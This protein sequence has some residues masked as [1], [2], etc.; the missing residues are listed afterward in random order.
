MVYARSSSLRSAGWIAV[1]AIVCGSALACERSAPG[2]APGIAVTVLDLGQAVAPAGER[3]A[4][5]VEPITTVAVRSQVDGAVEALAKV[6][7]Q[8]GAAHPLQIGDTV[9]AGDF[10]VQIERDTYQQRVGVE[11]AK[12]DSAKVSLALQL[13]EYDRAK[14]LFKGGVESKEF[15]DNARTAY[16]SAQAAVAQQQHSLNEAKIHLERTRVTSPLDGV[17][18]KVAIEPG[19]TVRPQSLLAQV[20]DVSSVNVTFGVPAGSVAALSIGSMLHMTFDAIAGD[21]YAAPITKIAPS[22]EA[23]NGVFDVTLTLPNPDGLLRPGYVA[24]VRV[25]REMIETATGA[26]LTIPLDAVIRPPDDAKGF[27]VYVVEASP[28]TTPREGVARIRSVEL[29]A[30]VGNRVKVRSGLGGNE[31]IIVRG[32]TLVHDGSAVRIIP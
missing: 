12:L 20:G 30:P 1:V 4:A 14:G 15:V 3:Y 21:E 6:K 25:P 27:G 11:Q 18:L 8:S 24:E 10:L 22:A 5:R 7:P 23:M 26:N 2:P 17:V 16:A 9:A 29:G 13:K 28:S 19:D 32:S 31:R